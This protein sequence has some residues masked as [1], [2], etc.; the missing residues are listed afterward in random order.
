MRVEERPW[1]IPKQG[2]GSAAMA[3]LVEICERAGISFAPVAKPADLFADA[4]L[5]ASGG[6]L[7][8]L[9]SSAGGTRLPRC[10]SSSGR[11]DPGCAASRRA[12]AST[13]ARSWPASASARRRSSR[14][15]R[16]GV[17]IAEEPA[18]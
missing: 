9:I 11:S 12:S 7:D 10:R 17:V 2:C 15:E 18:A 4:H 1:L 6:L 5:L 14:L 16:R 13:P 8:V 3:E